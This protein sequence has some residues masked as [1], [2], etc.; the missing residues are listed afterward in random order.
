VATTYEWDEE[1]NRSNVSKH[2]IAFQNAQDVFDDPCVA[3]KVDRVVDG[4]ERWQSVG[5]IGGD[6]M[7]LV[8]HTWKVEDGQETIRIISARKAT[9][10]EIRDFEAQS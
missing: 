9:P 5:L 2:G 10:K 7:I 3:S 4:E 6:L 1:K 8:A